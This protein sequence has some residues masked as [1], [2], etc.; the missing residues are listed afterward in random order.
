M[1][2]ET[3]SC[4]CLIKLGLICYLLGR[5]NVIYRLPQLCL[6]GCRMATR[7]SSL[8]L[9][10]TT[11]QEEEKGYIERRAARCLDLGFCAC[12]KPSF[13]SCLLCDLEEV[14]L[15]AWNHLKLHSG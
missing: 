11:P 14:A 10:P 5:V 1:P 8:P 4:L 9:S 3:V 13:I 12:F 2:V 15:E 7:I 6:L